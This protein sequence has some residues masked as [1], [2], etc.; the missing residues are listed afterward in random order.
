MKRHHHLCDGNARTELILLFI[1]P[2]LRSSVWICFCLIMSVRFP[3]IACFFPHDYVYPPLIVLF[4]LPATL[5]LH[6]PEL[7]LLIYCKRLAVL[8]QNPCSVTAKAL[9]HH[10]KSLAVGL[11]EPCKN[12]AVPVGDGYDTHGYKKGRCT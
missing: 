4:F 10:C 12:P 7:I 11:Q 8:L 1:T 6:F 2:L 5:Y 9:Q 3:K